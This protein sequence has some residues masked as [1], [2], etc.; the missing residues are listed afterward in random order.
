GVFVEL[1]RASTLLRQQSDLLERRN[2]ELQHAIERSWRAEE[3]IKGLNRHLERQI[4]ELAEV[5]RELEAF[6]FTASHDLRGPL[7][8]IAGFSKALLESHA[9]QLDETGRL[10]LDRIE[11][12][13]GRMCELVE[14][15]L[16]FS[17]ITRDR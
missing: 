8:R 10:Y 12:S 2:D 3:E 4:A 9:G 5:N 14:D 7:S 11:H 16:K 6:S 17:R 15:L 13:A 1:N